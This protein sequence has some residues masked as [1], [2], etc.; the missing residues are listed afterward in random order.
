MAA[1]DLLATEME[2]ALL[3]TACMEPVLPCLHSLADALES[4]AV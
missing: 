2:M 4:M 3:Q 1:C